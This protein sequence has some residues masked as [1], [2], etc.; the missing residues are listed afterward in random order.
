MW[1]LTLAV[2]A[3]LAANQASAA[4]TGTDAYKTCRDAQ[5]NSYTVQQIGN[6]TTVRGRNANTGSTW[7]QSTQRIGNSSYTRGRD[8]DGNSWNASSSTYGNT[9]YTRGRDSDGNS[10]SSTTSRVGNS[11]YTYGRDSDGDSYSSSSYSSP[12]VYNCDDE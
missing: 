6:Q 3:M 11:T 8:R 4:C 10:F 2:A 1:K 12:C 7:S 5:G 9:T